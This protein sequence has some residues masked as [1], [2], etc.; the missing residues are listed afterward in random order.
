[1]HQY[2]THQTIEHTRGTTTTML[3]DENYSFSNQ[4]NW[5][6]EPALHFL[7]GD[8]LQVTCTYNNTSGS[9]VQFG[10]SSTEEM[11]FAGLYVYPAANFLFGCVSGI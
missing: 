3:L 1:M 2:A 4:Q 10:D 11:C 5:P 9:T 7:S 8:R 6:Q